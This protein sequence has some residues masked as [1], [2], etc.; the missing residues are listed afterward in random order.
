MLGTEL[1][2]ME[3]VSPRSALPR[4]ALIHLMPVALPCHAVPSHS[5]L[6]HHVMCC[7]VPCQVKLYVLCHAMPFWP[8]AGTSE[9]PT[10]ATA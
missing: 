7:S 9:E 3:N 2:V 6:S 1:L 8:R 4:A 5:V 10:E